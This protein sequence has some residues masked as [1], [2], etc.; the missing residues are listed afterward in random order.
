[1]HLLLGSTS[2]GLILIPPIRHFRQFPR[3]E[4]KRAQAPSSETDHLAL[5]E[6]C[7][8]QGIGFE[9]LTLSLLLWRLNHRPRCSAAALEVEMGEVFGVLRAVIFAS[10]NTKGWG[11]G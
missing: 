6:V 9:S 1:M 11:A 8:L 3:A 2:L 5:F 7:D 4:Y 10:E